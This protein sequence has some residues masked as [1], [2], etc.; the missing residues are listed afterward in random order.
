MS[1][2]ATEIVV[3]DENPSPDFDAMSDRELLL[4]IAKSHHFILSIIMEVKDQVMP[5]IDGL[6]KSP[7]LRP[8]IG[9]K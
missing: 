1:E 6:V 3:V 9:G 5:T 2:H 4:H 7:L 8:F